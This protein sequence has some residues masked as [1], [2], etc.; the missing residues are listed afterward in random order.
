M[1]KDRSKVDVPDPG[2][3]ENT[4]RCPS[5]HCLPIQLPIYMDNHAT[6]R[7]DPRVL[8]A[9]LPF[10]TE[11]FGNPGSVTHE[12]GREANDAVDVARGQIATAI[13]AASKE[14]VFTSGATESNNL[15]IH[16]VAEK[17]R[18]RGKHLISV[19]TEH[20][21][22]LE[23]LQKLARRG[24]DVTWLPVTQSPDKLPK[25]FGPTRF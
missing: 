15:A 23:P 13:G 22:V 4:L 1:G 5:R 21:S 14:I 7:L 19:T 16:G 11:K 12:F 24:F 18:H 2:C 8:E 20:P 3:N 17:L 25:P 9:M 10:F 6:T